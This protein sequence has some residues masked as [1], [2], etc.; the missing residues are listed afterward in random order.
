M[1]SDCN[2]KEYSSRTTQQIFKIH[3]YSL[4]IL[5][6]KSVLCSQALRLWACLYPRESSSCKLKITRMDLVRLRPFILIFLDTYMKLNIYSLKAECVDLNDA[7]SVLI[8]PF[9]SSLVPRCIDVPPR[10]TSFPQTQTSR[11]LNTVRPLRDPVARKQDAEFEVG[12]CVHPPRFK[13][14]RR[15]DLLINNLSSTR[16][17]H[18]FWCALVV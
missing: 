4:K 7:S 9:D 12:C 17:S 3:N 15:N 18:L 2:L 14:P 6:I 5:Q 1:L 11:C 10:S 13:V 16:L 8:I